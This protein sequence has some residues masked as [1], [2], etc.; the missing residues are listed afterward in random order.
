MTI[1]DAEYEAANKVGAKMMKRGPIVVFAAYDAASR[2]LLMTFANGTALTT[3]VDNVQGLADADDADLALVEIASL[4]LGLHWPR[5]DADVWVPD[6][7]EGVTGTRAWLAA[8]GGAAK[9]KAK[10][11]AARRNGLKGGRP[12]KIEA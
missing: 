9:S 4:G 1:S 3:P 11:V 12:K 7:L 10:A 8:R 2:T 5:L 6:L